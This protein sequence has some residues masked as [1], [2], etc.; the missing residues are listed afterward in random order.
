MPSKLGS[1][2]IGRE[3][4]ADDVE[5]GVAAHVDRRQDRL[6]RLVGHDRGGEV[7]KLKPGAGG[8]PLPPI[9]PPVQVSFAAR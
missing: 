7:G 4:G 3:V 8:G 5:L 2:S 6:L 9:L 1:T